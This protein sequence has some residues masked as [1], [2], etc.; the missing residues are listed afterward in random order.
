VEHPGATLCQVFWGSAAIFS[1]VNR[2][3][4]T[5]SGHHGTVRLG[6]HGNQSSS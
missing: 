2:W 6:E 4:M 1:S 5:A 3:V